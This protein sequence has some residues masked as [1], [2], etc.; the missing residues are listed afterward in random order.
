MLAGW[1]EG[2]VSRG[3]PC[4]HDAL[5]QI[6]MER[7]RRKRRRKEKPGNDSVPLGPQLL[8]SEDRWTPGAHGRA[9]LTSRW[10]L[11][12]VRGLISKSNVESN[13][14][15]HLVSASVPDIRECVHTW[16]QLHVHRKVCM[17][18]VRRTERVI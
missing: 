9:I 12:S 8:G 14:G 11:G 1:G 10:T 13:P 6:P 18:Q 4:G 5:V 7:M 2:S 16:T 17:K 3:P 15:K